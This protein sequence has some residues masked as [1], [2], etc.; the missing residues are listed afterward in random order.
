MI[1][2]RA[3][4]LLGTLV[5]VGADDARAIDAAFAAIERLQALLSRFEPASDVARFNALP[6]GGAIDVAAPTAR[7]LA[8]AARL[9]AASDGA[10]DVALGSG[11]WRLEGRRLAKLDAATRLDLGGIGKGEAVDR[12]VR[13]L[14]R[15]GCAAGYVNAG[16]DLSVFGALALPVV[17]RDEHGGGVRP[18]CELREGALATSRYAGGVRPSRSALWAHGAAAGAPAIEAHVSVAAPRCVWAD[19]LTKVVAASGR[20]DHP[21]LARHGARAWRH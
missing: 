16:G 12:A 21:L 8:L 9:H 14:R 4:P 18:F 11:G 19:A 5:E 15:A 3:R 13:A 17:L 7:L 20:L 2:R 1:A 6:A 10:F